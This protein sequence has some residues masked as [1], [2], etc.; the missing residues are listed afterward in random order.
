MLS[1]SSATDRV[2][3]LCRSAS[4]LRSSESSMKFLNIGRYGEFYS[5]EPRK[6]SQ[7]DNESYTRLSRCCRRGK[8]EAAIHG[9]SEGFVHRTS[10]IGRRELS[11]AHG[12]GL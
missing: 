12:L 9:R 1:P 11:R 10:A 2:A 7:T 6:S 5:P 4:N 8:R 3:S